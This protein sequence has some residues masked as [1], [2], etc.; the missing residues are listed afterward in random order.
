MGIKNTFYTLLRENN[1][2]LNEG[3]LGAKIGLSAAE[4]EQVLAQLL[5]EHRIEYAEHKACSYRIATR[6]RKSDQH[7]S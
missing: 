5:A 4:T 6:S 7:R 2:W 1:G 3:E